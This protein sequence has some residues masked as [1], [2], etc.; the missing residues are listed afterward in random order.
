VLGVSLL[1]YLGN[2]LGSVLVAGL[3]YQ[4]GTFSGDPG[5][6]FVVTMAAKKMHLGF[7][8]AF[9]RGILCNWLVVLSVWCGYRLKSESGKLIMVFWCLLAF[10]ASGYEHSIANMALLTLANLLPHGP[11][12]GWMGLIDNLLPVTLGN[13][14]SGTV[15]MAAAYWYIDRSAES[16]EPSRG[17]GLE[18]SRH[19]P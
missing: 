13:I 5:G 17:L 18:R 19:R 7:G 1:N 11:G 9:C 4:A 14:V 6:A 12:I 2:F 15:F 8:Q 3:V 16:R 10:I